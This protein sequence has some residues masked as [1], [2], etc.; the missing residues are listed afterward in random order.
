MKTAW[1]NFLSLIVYW[2]GMQAS[3][4]L[5]NSFLTDFRCSWQSEL[6]TVEYAWWHRTGT[7]SILSLEVSYSSQIYRSYHYQIQNW[8][9]VSIID[10]HWEKSGA[11]TA[12]LWS[13]FGKQCLFGSWSRFLNLTGLPPSGKIRENQGKFWPSGKSGKVREFQ[14]F[15]S[16][17]RESQGKWSGWGDPKF[18]P[19]F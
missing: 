13:H 5:K 11:K 12:P 4:T 18:V 15:L 10:L 7:L 16:I 2:N 9:Y 17:V 19:D 8:F 3:H 14:Y 6:S 1:H